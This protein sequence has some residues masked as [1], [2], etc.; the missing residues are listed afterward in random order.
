[1]FP[2]FRSSSGEWIGNKERCLELLQLEI[3]QIL[4]RGWLKVTKSKTWQWH[5]FS[6]LHWYPISPIKKDFGEGC[7]C[8]SHTWL[9]RDPSLQH[10]AE[11]R[12]LGRGARWQTRAMFGSSKRKYQIRELRCSPCL[13]ASLLLLCDVRELSGVTRSRF[14][15]RVFRMYVCCCWHFVHLLE[16]R[17]TSL[18][19][20]SPKINNL[21]QNENMIIIFFI[22]ERTVLNLKKI[23]N[24]TTC[25]RIPHVTWTASYSNF[26]NICFVHR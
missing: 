10:G 24:Q 18:R 15:E 13:A 2:S 11:I 8:V 12:A 9:L 5:L 6:L 25:N 3:T 16:Q 17:Q 22:L 26:F 1:M 21:H 14:L 4:T 19:L 20:L 23:Y 7:S